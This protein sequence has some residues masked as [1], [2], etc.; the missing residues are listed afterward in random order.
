M[1][2]KLPTLLRRILPKYFN[3]RTIKGKATT[4]RNRMCGVTP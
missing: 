2:M 4:T 1:P 3:I